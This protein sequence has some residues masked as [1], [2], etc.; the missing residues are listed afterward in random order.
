MPARIPPGA[1]AGGEADGS[2]AGAAQVLATGGLAAGFNLALLGLLVWLVWL[3][4]DPLFWRN[5]GGW[6]V[7]LRETVLWAFYPL[8]ALETAML[9]GLTRWSL[10]VFRGLGPRRA[11]A[12]LTLLSL[13][14]G[15]AGFVLL[16]LVANNVD[17]L[18]QGR[19]AHWHTP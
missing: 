1:E 19:P 16:F 14:W 18:L 13:S 4:E 3:K 9:V 2:P 12:A 15:L 7:W 8:L 5:A 17:N 6:P 11:L 10:R